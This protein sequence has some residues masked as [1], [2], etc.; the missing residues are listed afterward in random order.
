MQILRNSQWN[1]ILVHTRG[2]PFS[3]CIK[4][5]TRFILG[6]PPP[7]SNTF[8]SPH[9]KAESPDA[10]FTSVFI[11]KTVSWES[12]TLD[13]RV[14][15]KEYFPL[16]KED[17]NRDNLGKFSAHKS[18]GLIGRQL[19][20]LRELAEMI[21]KQFSI[22]FERQWEWERCLR[23]GGKAVSLQSSKRARR[24][25]WEATGQSASPLSVGKWWSS[26]FWISSSSKRKNRSLSRIGKMGSLRKNCV[27]PV[28]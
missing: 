20:V 23:T 3:V 1:L 28:W 5:V 12:Q 18:M 11:T 25:N 19:W 8:R 21:A 16:G 9:E 4:S 10:F 14:W 17:L 15:G 26:L 27:L 7:S 2:L 24:R 22:I 13:I 6:K